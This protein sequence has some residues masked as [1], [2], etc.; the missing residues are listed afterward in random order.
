MKEET[1]TGDEAFVA[2]Q[3]EAAAEEAASIGGEGSGGDVPDAERPVAEGGGGVSEGFE[4]AEE[5]LEEHATHGEP[6]PDPS[7][8]AGEPEEPD[9][10][11][12]VHG[13]ADRVDASE[14]SDP[15]DGHDLSGAR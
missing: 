6:G 7:H 9:A 2:E 12:A 10:A 3:E 5:L 4:Q 11:D 1:P 15:E 8:L 14:R 13:D